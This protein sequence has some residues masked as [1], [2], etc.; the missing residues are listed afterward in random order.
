MEVI[1]VKDGTVPV[2]VAKVVNTDGGVRGGLTD[3][4]ESMDPDGDMHQYV[5]AFYAG[6]DGTR[7]IGVTW[8]DGDGFNVIGFIGLNDALTWLNDGATDEAIADSNLSHGDRLHWAIT[9]DPGD[10]ESYGHVFSI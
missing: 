9:Y 2:A 8:A 4:L 10:D 7:Y 6:D 3:F 1:I 5:E